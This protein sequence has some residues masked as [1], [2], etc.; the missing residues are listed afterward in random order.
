MLCGILTTLLAIPT[1]IWLVSYFSECAVSELVFLSLFRLHLTTSS[2]ESLAWD[3]S[4]CV[5]QVPASRGHQEEVQ[6]LLGTYH[7]CRHWN[8]PLFG[9]EIGVSG[10]EF[11][12]GFAPR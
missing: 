9:C 8:W 7:G 12:A 4:G 3:S 11:G 1:A 2:G 10:T 5:D 6:R